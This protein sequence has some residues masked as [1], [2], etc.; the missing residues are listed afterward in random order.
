M[1]YFN[2]IIKRLMLKRLLDFLDKNC[3]LSKYQ[4][5]FRKDHSTTLAIIEIIENIRQSL[6]NGDSRVYIYKCK[7]F[8][9]VDHE[10]FLYKL[11]YYGIRGHV[12]KWFRH[13]LSN[14]QQCISINGAV[15]EYAHVQIGVPRGSILGLV[16]FLL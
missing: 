13:Y 15:S 2:K 3:V 8:D 9:V 10:V 4:F 11:D 14:R 5:G 16:L 1:N 6:E 7:A 12:C